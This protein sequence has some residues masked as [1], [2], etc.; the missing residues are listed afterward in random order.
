[1]P[2]VRAPLTAF[3][4]GGKALHLAADG[5]LFGRIK[6]R[7]IHCDY[8][9]GSLNPKLWRSDFCLPDGASLADAI[10]AQDDMQ[11]ITRIDAQDDLGE[12]S[13]ESDCEAIE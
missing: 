3:G 8:K 12:E 9:R 10:E 2:N 1:M 4:R 7:L 5:L 6:N 11:I 13:D